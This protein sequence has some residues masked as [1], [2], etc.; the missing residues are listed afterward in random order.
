MTDTFE[1]IERQEQPVISVRRRTP[2]A[3][4]NGAIAQAY[5]EI[6]SYLGQLGENPADTPFTAYYNMD[7]QDLD[8]EIGV[9]VS[10][11]LPG[12]GAVQQSVIPAGRQASCMYKG[13]YSEIGE[14][15]AALEA[16]AKEKGVA[17]TGVSYEYYLNTPGQVPDSELLT[18]IVF[19]LK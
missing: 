2:V 1:I 14:A 11:P 16:W 3:G 13:P 4:L 12:G 5:Q 15:Y 19:L 18:K 8:V 9:A 17:P 10:R 6:F 7:M